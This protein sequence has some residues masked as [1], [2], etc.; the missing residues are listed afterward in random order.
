MEDSKNLDFS[1]PLYQICNPVVP[2]KKHANYPMASF[3]V[4][5]ADL[6]KPAQHL[7]PV[8]DSTH[9]S[10]CCRR[11]IGSDVIVNLAKPGLGFGGPDY[12]AQ[13]EIRRPISS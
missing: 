4:Q 1:F 7:C 9:R 12:L 5:I 3:R 6:G 13:E 2:I 8:I 11:V 10:L